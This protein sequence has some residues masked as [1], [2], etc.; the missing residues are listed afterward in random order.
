MAVGTK[1]HQTQQNRIDALYRRLFAQPH[2]QHE[3]SIHHAQDNFD[4]HA[5]TLITEEYTKAK[6]VYNSMI[7]PYERVLE[8][9][10]K[11]AESYREYVLYAKN[12]DE[13]AVRACTSGI[14]ERMLIDHSLDVD[15]WKF[16]AANAEVC[17]CVRV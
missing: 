7:L 10:Q 9:S 5:D 15:V 16:A 6:T 8:R 14:I 1:A 3:K 17:V 12:S 2:A 4:E 13:A 11:T